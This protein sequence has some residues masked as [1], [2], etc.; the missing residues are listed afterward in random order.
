[1]TDS[2]KDEKIREFIFEIDNMGTKEF[3]EFV[4][5]PTPHYSSTLTAKEL[6]QQF[7]T[8]DAIRYKTIVEYAKTIRR[9]E[10]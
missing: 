1:M 7:I 6:S 5:S 3:C 8:I 10:S 2:E 9:S 4:G